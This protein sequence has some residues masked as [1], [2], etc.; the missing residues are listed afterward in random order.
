MDF[1]T[2]PEPRLDPAA[3]VA[4]TPAEVANRLRNLGSEPTR[5]LEFVLGALVLVAWVPPQVP[6]TLSLGLIAVTGL[7]VVAALR[8]P[9]WGRTGLG[10][11]LVAAVVLLGYLVSV[12]LLTPDESLSGWPKRA[13]RLLLVLLFLVSI[14]TGRLHLPSL[15]R[16]MAIGLLG[17]AVLFY[18]GIAPAPYGAYLSGFLLDKNVAGMVYLVVGLL[19]AGLVSTRLR[20]AL[21][22]L[23]TSAAVWGTGSRTSLAA[24]GCALAWFWLRPRLRPWGRLLLAGGLAL[25]VRLLEVDYAQVGVFVERVGSDN[26][27][28][29]IDAASQVK[30]DAT[31]WFG[32]GLGTAFVPIEGDT[33]FFHNSYWSALVEGGWVLLV[34]YVGVHV[35]FGIGPT[36]TGPPI[37]RW[38]TAAEAANVAVLV[39]ALRLG[40]VFGTTG[41]AL[42]LGAGLL[43]HIGYHAARQAGDPAQVGSGDSGTTDA[44]LARGAGP[45]PGRTSS[46]APGAPPV[47]GSLSR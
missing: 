27:R 21:V 46:P 43:G 11:L 38:A 18:A 8:R 35:W 40:E 26:L 22:L 29:R 34:A 17:N 12:S 28:A 44:D 24:L 47:A 39:C 32:S 5:L 3:P 10:W 16:G 14:V 19:L 13:L 20:R 36:R 4:S 30:L 2:A 1:R 31:P 9:A 25:L 6:A 37:A 15:V 7:V 41:A 33:F 42:A 23:A 45:P